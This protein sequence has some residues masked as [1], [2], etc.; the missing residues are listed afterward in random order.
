MYAD[1]SWS[2][3]INTEPFDYKV[4]ARAKGISSYTTK[5]TS[6]Q[7]LK[8][9]IAIDVTQPAII[10]KPVFKRMSNGSYMAEFQPVQD[11]GTVYEYYVEAIGK[12]TGSIYES[13]VKEVT[14]QSGMKGYA[15]EVSKSKTPTPSTVTA[16]TSPM[17]FTVPNSTLLGDE[18]FYVHMKAIDS[19]GNQ[20]VYTTF[21][22]S[23]TAYLVITPTTTDWTNKPITLTITGSQGIGAIKMLRLP[24]GSVVNSSSA[25]FVVSEN[26]NYPFYGQDEFGQWMSGGYTV[27]NIENV[28][29]DISI[30]NLSPDWVNKDISIQI[31]AK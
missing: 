12:N 26:G 3:D 21:Y 1:L 17:S 13:P 8:E 29:P 19:L 11:L 14:V 22:E 15:I 20:S 6:S 18:P 23:S 4:Y 10:S 24:N 30:P 5:T 7:T 28:K 25:T 31:E 27:T 16:T 9:T 2:F